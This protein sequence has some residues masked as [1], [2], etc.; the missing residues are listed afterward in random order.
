[1]HYGAVWDMGL[2]HCGICAT[3]LSENSIS[4]VMWKDICK[5]TAIKQL[6]N[7]NKHEQVYPLGCTSPDSRVHGANMVPIW[8]R[9][10]PGGPHVGPMNLA[11][12]IPEILT[13]YI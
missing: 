3:G 10:D 12:A 9:Q 6:Q 13:F 8:G 4:G 2:A 7:K 1:M 5:P 11:N